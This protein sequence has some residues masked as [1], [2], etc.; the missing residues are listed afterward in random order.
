MGGEQPH[1]AQVEPALGQRLE[2]DREVARGARRLD[3]LVGGVLGEAE[4]EDAVGVQGGEAGRQVE[5]PS[6]D[7][8]QDRD[9]LGGGGALL[10]Q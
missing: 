5:P 10:P 8:G 7:L 4:L 2:E 6:V 9:Q 3:A 1:A